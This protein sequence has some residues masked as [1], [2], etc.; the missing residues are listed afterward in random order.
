MLNKSK[1][2]ITISIL[3]IT[4]LV[5][6]SETDQETTGESSYQ[7]ITIEQNQLQ[8]FV[9]FE[10]DSIAQPQDIEVLPNGNV[11]VLY[12]GLKSVLVFNENGDRVM[13]F[14]REGKGPGEFVQPVIL[15]LTKNH[16]YILDQG[17]NFWQK[18]THNGE[19]VES[20]QNINGGIMGRDAHAIADSEYLIPTD[21]RG[22][23]LVQYKNT[24]SDSSYYFGKPMGDSTIVIDYPKNIKQAQN[25]EVPDMFKNLVFLAHTDSAYFAFLKSY[26]H[27]QKYS[28]SGELLWEK[29]LE[30]PS[31]QAIFD[32]F[33][34]ANEDQQEAA[35]Y[36]LLYALD[37]GVA[38]QSIYLLM[39]APGDENQHLVALNTQGNIQT[40]YNM[41]IR[42]ELTR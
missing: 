22:E 30:L 40:V 29:E 41:P 9:T 3:F 21:G 10:Q 14:G 15:E 4:L 42:W 19:F 18:Y 34:A 36:I 12:F 6:S 7:R 27:L 35:I 38:H 11:A 8:P 25:G 26:G 33:V 5:G 1:L 39:N 28:H 13:S 23:A 24:N 37:M 32:E 17:Q 16:L 2:S 20:L 31:M